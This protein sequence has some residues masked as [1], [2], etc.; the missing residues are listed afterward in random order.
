MPVIRSFIETETAKQKEI[1]NALPD[2][3]NKDWT[4]L[5]TVFRKMISGKG[6]VISV[7]DS[8][9]CGYI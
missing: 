7:E 8:V 1:A 2:D 3:H 6:E 4:A 5:N 9:A